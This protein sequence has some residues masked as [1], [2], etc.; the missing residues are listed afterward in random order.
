M[1]LGR[2]RRLRTPTWFC[3]ESSPMDSLTA[4]HFL[5]VISRFVSDNLTE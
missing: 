2:G 5:F 4:G 3:Q 1:A